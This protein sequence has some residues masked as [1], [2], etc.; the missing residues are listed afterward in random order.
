[1]QLNR[2]DEIILG[3]VIGLLYC[4]YHYFYI[5]STFT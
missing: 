1:M 3:I 5:P 2:K 4:D